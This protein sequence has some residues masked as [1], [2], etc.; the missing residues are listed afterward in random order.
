MKRMFI[1]TTIM[2]VFFLE[3]CWVLT[4]RNLVSPKSSETIRAIH[5]YQANPSPE[6]ERLLMK[7]IH[8]DI[9]RNGR[10][11]AI[12]FYAMVLGDIGFLVLL[13]KNGIMRRERPEVSEPAIGHS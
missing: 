13:W 6:G 8:R 1:I 4:P 7:E 3:A 9:K 12:T 2:A 5:A 11:Y 10:P